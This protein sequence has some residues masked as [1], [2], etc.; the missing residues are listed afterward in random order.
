VKIKN[1][2]LPAM[3][4]IRRDVVT[5]EKPMATTLKDG[6]QRAAAA[7][8]K[9]ARARDGAQALREYEAEQV[10]LRAKTARLRALRLA[11]EA[12]S[13]Q[14]TKKQQPTKKIVGSC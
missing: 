1:P 9:E 7:A 4:R 3:M 6:K 5:K 11:Q 10:A 14:D 2:K 8:S 12:G 13:T